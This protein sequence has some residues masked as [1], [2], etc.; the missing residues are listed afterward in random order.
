MIPRINSDLVEKIVEMYNLGYGTMYIAKNLGVSRC[1]VQKYLIL[2]GIDLRKTSPRYHYNI[3]FFSCYDPI[4]AYWAGF[5]AADGYIRKNRAA[6]HIKLKK[7]DYSHLLK[8]C[9]AIDYNNLPKIAKNNKY[10]YIDASG[11][12]F[13]DDLRT[14]YKL[15]PNKAFNVNISEDIPS[16]YL[17]H[18]VRGYF[19]GDGSI[20]WSTT[21]CISFTSASTM[22]LDQLRLIFKNKLK[23]KIKSKNDVPPI[24][25]NKAI[26]YSGKNAGI[27]LRWMY[28][29]S[30]ESIRLS[31]KYDRYLKYYL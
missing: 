17:S 16:K 20:S 25:Y 8:F 2:K 4:S 9:T 23:I 14:N 3:K 21:S 28:K 19:D 27:I 11:K 29:N 12:W 24:F 31:R 18:F 6:L 15:A 7:N 26:S 5:I 10:C 30:D 22:I 1:T 13:I